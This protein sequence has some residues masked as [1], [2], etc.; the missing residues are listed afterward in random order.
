MSASG[1]DDLAALIV[2]EQRGFR[3]ILYAGLGTLLLMAIISI[4]MGINFY[5]ISAELTATNRR[6]QEDAFE[7]RR[8]FAAQNN[9]LAT[10]E[11]AMRRI[12]TEVRRVTDGGG[13]VEATPQRVAEARTAVQQYLMRGHLP[14]LSDQRAIR[15]FGLRDVQGVSPQ[16]KAL[17]AGAWTIV[18][19]ENNGDAIPATAEALPARLQQAV[20]SFQAAR[21]DPA[22]DSLARA[23]IAWVRF[24]DASSPRRNYAPDACQAVF[25]AVEGLHNGVQAPRPL[26][27][28]AQC[29][30]KTGR[31]T[32]ALANYARSLAASAPE[33]AAIAASGSGNRRETEAENQLAL[34]AYHGVGTTLI[35]SADEAD[36]AP[37][38]ADALATARQ[39][40]TPLDAAAPG[41]S[42]RMRLAVACLRRAI[43]LRRELGQTDNQLS[44]TA[45][46]LSF[47]YLR[48]GDFNAAYENAVAVEQTGLFPWNEA[49]RALTA[50]HATS[51]ERADRRAIAREARR[52]VS[53]FGVPQFNLCELRQLM[54]PEDFQALS[55]LIASEHGGETAQCES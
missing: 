29:E 33:A 36:D 16:L 26:Y 52:N 48:D 49:V 37:G 15:Q 54:R 2:R 6:L 4:A 31:T 25:E 53:L 45:E 35:A 55:V 39:W 1:D 47:A 24:T 14:S 21:A 12:Y 51:G 10:Q 30:R 3:R 40:C 8:A 23:G 18:S 27:W 13:D 17:M 32:D 20:E 38:M 28:R 19:F 43:A 44:G 34:D 9:R 41:R 7:S 22:L 42:E 11:R 50:Q 46:N 5:S